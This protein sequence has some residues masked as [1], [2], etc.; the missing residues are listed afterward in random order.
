MRAGAKVAPSLI[1]MA[2]AADVLVICLTDY[3]AIKAVLMTDQ[4]G[5]ALRD[6]TLVN[7]TSMGVE[8]LRELAG[9]TGKNGIPL[10][11]GS[12]LTYPDDVRAGKSTMV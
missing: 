9:W 5:D 1:D 10:I 8:D 6:R 4:L 7:V 2:G 3:T 12:I 11:K